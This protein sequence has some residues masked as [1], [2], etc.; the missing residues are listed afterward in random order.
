MA[1]ARESEH[2]SDKNIRI[3]YRL[4]KEAKELGINDREAEYCMAVGEMAGDMLTVAKELT[5]VSGD[6]QPPFVKQ[7]PRERTS[8]IGVLPM[9]KGE[10]KGDY[11]LARFT[12]TNVVHVND[13]GH[14]SFI[15]SRLIKRYIDPLAP[16]VDLKSPCVEF[17]KSFFRAWLG[18]IN[19]VHPKQRPSLF[20][21]FKKCMNGEVMRQIEANQLDLYY[22]GPKAAANAFR[23]MNEEEENAKEVLPDGMLGDFLWN[24]EILVRLDLIFEALNDG[25]LLFDK[26]DD[27]YNAKTDAKFANALKKSGGGSKTEPME[28]KSHICLLGTYKAVNVDEQADEMVC[29]NKLPVTTGILFVQYVNKGHNVAMLVDA[30]TFKWFLGSFLT[31]RANVGWVARLD[32]GMRMPFDMIPKELRDRANAMI[33]AVVKSRQERKAAEASATTG[34]PPEKAKAEDPK[35]A[36]GNG[37]SSTLGDQLL[38]KGQVPGSNPPPAA[39]EPKPADATPPVPPVATTDGPS[40]TSSASAS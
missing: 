8:G 7:A 34:S 13:A 25:K 6:K 12:V 14:L 35:P 38:A 9:W 30:D 3:G 26:D 2:L 16:G 27:E 37:F 10:W 1:T 28:Y 15:N 22:L 5:D 4:V 11:P 20:R 31:Q 29:G 39:E 36:N 40:D 21:R 33:D 24:R 17:E 32:Y 18:Q 23:P 19:Y